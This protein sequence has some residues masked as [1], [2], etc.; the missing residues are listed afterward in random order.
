MQKIELIEMTARN[1]DD[2]TAKSVVAS[3]TPTTVDALSLIH[4]LSGQLKGYNLFFYGGGVTQSRIISDFEPANNRMVIQEAFTATP[5]TA[6]AF[7]VFERFSG[8]DYEYAFRNAYERFYDFRTNLRDTWQKYIDQIT[9]LQDNWHSTRS[10]EQSSWFTTQN[11]AQ[12]NWANLKTNEQSTWVSGAE[13]NQ[14]NWAAEQTN[15][16]NALDEMW[17][18]THN[19]VARQFRNPAFSMP[20]LGIVAPGSIAPGTLPIGTIPIGSMPI[21][22]LMI[23]SLSLG[24]AATMSGISSYGALVADDPILMSG[25]AEYLSSR[26]ISES[27]EW[28]DKFTNFQNDVKQAKTEEFQVVDEL[29]KSY[30]GIWAK[31][32]AEHTSSW[33]IHRSRYDAAWQDYRNNHDA[34]WNAH[35][36]RFETNWQQL[37]SDYS[38][39]KALVEQ[40]WNQIAKLYIEASL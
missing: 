12:N 34:L 15:W 16:K 30:D 25:M 22:T 26:K 20:T 10:N 21:G 3:A 19:K 40:R 35:K 39:Y 6:G 28:R 37:R 2:L 24:I 7:M 4:P 29:V 23:P 11:G 17:K 8:D 1:V 38:E 13:A 31:A 5:T 27:Q 9:R 14:V 18:I 36:Q 33:E 32:N